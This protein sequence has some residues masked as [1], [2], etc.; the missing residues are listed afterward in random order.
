[1]TTIILVLAAT[2]IMLAGAL[3][4]ALCLSV[5]YG[6]TSASYRLFA[7][8]DKLVRLDIAGDIDPD[9]PWFNHTYEQVNSLLQCSYMLSKTRGWIVADQAGKRFAERRFRV[10]AKAAQA[11]DHRAKA[12]TSRP[13]EPLVPILQELDLALDQLL[14]THMGWIILLNSATRQYRKLYKQKAKELDDDIHRG[15]QMAH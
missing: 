5:L 4:L 15:L 11:D 2:A 1:M 8:R 10:R 12:P 6:D 13:P 7:V 3:V 14:N 9:D